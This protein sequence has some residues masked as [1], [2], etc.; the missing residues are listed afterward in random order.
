MIHSK[1]FSL[2]LLALVV[3][4]GVSVACT[5]TPPAAP[6]LQPLVITRTASEPS[7]AVLPTATSTV[8]ATSS[9]A[10]TLDATA[11]PVPSSTPAP[12]PTASPL[13][14]NTPTATADSVKQTCAPPGG[15]FG[16][17]W[18]RYADR[19]GC[20]LA[21]R[22][23]TITDAEQVFQ[24]GHMFWWKHLDLH[25]VVYSQGARAG[26]YAMYANE[27]VAGEAQ[28]SCSVA[29]PQGFVQPVRGFGRV[30]CRLGADKAAIGW[31]LA[32]EV[33]FEAGNADPLVQ[34]FERG[35]IF[36]D[37]DGFMNRLAYVFFDDGTFVRQP[38]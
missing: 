14:V 23:T 15:V 5:S 18:Q 37:S 16:N 24:N 9:L 32:L 2:V 35:F 36:R 38:Y 30:W 13:P 26:T 6:T 33:S 21:N 12:T 27:W 7:P 20:P 22:P 34:R 1:G 10:P 4:V 8:A 25:L 3:V 17:L 31:A 11:T 28:A 19:L 29:V